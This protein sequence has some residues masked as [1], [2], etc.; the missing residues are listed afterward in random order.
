MKIFFDELNRRLAVCLLLLV[1][2]MLV[3]VLRVLVLA[4]DR[5]LEYAA[6]S[7]SS[8]SVDLYRCRGNFYDTN[9]LPITSSSSK[10]MSVIT[11]TPQGIV[12]ASSFL[13]EGEYAR[14]LTRLG[15]G[16]GVL[17]DKESGALPGIIP[18]KIPKRYSNEQ[19]AVHIVGYINGDGHGVSGLEAGLDDLLHSDKFAKIS[20]TVDAANKIL[21]GAQP[22]MQNNDG[23]NGVVLTVD[24][25]FQNI[26]ENA[27]KIADKGAVVVT[28]AKNGKIRAMASV[29]EYNPSRPLE[30]VEDDDSPFINRALNAYSVGSVFKVCV[31]AAA[32]DNG[33]E[34]Y[35][36]DCRGSIVIDGIKFNCHK[37]DGHGRMNMQ[38]ALANSCNCYFYNL[39]IALGGESIYNTAVSCG[40]GLPLE[41]G[42][43]LSSAGGVMPEIQAVTAL[44]G[45]LANFSIGQGRLLLTP[46][47]L[48]TLY[49]AVCCDGCY[50]MPHLIEGFVNDGKYKAKENSTAKTQVM[51]PETAR[52]LK[53]CLIEALNSGTGER[54]K[55]SIAVGGGKTATAQTG[56]LINGRQIENGW[57]C[58]FVEIESITYV[59]SVFVEDAV[60]GSHQGSQIFKAIADNMAKAGVSK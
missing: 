40:F 51:K 22:I 54:A 25:R 3:C 2:L 20:F 32:I 23:G 19:S 55:P 15:N 53:N 38:T 56:Q 24:L 50:V 13:K 47:S 41:I 1:S 6:T 16:F 27:L 58:G 26:V 44:K 17:V 11:A 35:V 37:K 57:F 34:D 49:G 45:E 42:G 33:L 39:A 5:Q 7:Q 12:S 60:A 28:E 46:L 36:Q 10:T 21:L 29:P 59:I 14:A 8:V 52:K 30:N 9:M 18:V 43:G 48:T 4:S 31:A